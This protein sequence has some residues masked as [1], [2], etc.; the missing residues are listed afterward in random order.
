M[1]RM[2]QR[3]KMSAKMLT[4]ITMSS[5]SKIMT[6]SK[7]KMPIKIARNKVIPRG[8]VVIMRAEASKNTEEKGVSVVQN[9]GALKVAV[10]KVVAED[11][12]AQSAVD[13][14]A[15]VVGAA[16]VVSEAVAVGAGANMAYRGA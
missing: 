2:L 15:A 1:V 16:V 11:L 14:E 4:K 9:V 6:N 10:V 12:A 7:K 13:S 5:A 3:I 8:A